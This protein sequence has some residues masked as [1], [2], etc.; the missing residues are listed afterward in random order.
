[1]ASFVHNG[2]A[3]DYTPGSA[4]SAGDV[5]VVGDI[6]GIA[7]RD[8]AASELGAIQV[9][10]VFEFP[11]ASATVVAA[12]AKVYWSAGSGLATVTNTDK[13]CGHAVAAAGNGATVVR[14][15]LDRA[16]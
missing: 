14:V 9:A 5:V 2:A 16:N 12:G 10:G 6:V 15:L 1:M 13:F 7:P 8:I 3:L 11:K 4:V